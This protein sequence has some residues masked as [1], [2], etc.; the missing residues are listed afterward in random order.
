[1]LGSPQ[2][3]EVKPFRA[4][5]YDESTAGP[6]E[7]LVAPPYDVISP[8]QRD[9]YLARSPYNVVHLTLPDDEAQAGRD[10]TAWRE[11]GVLARETKP[12]YWLLAQDYVGPD[13]VSRTRSG[14]VASLRAEPY[15]SGT[16]L[17]HERTHRGPKEGRLRLLRATHTQLEPIFLL[18]EGEPLQPP[19]RTPDLESGG[20]KL[21]RADDA[22]SFESTELLIADGHHRYET[23]VAYA[24]EG[25][26]PYL[27]VVLVP[28]KQEGLTIFPTHRLA[29][30]VNGARGT[31]IDEPGDDLPGVVLYRNGRYELLSGEGLDV[32]I[33]EQIAPEGVTYTP[34][35]A[36]AVATVDRGDAEAAF[37]LRPT[38]IE[39]VWA[40]ARRGET[41]PQKSTYFYP[42]LT[43]GLLFHP[44]D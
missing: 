10:L 40:V 3:A 35:R 26:S 8:E 24:Q 34:Q 30:H 9:E 15:E 14:L 18:Y 1:M 33:V 11:Q 6:L 43:S 25:G 44:L 29:A 37:L 41:M 22:P 13:G 42:K 21:W 19:A 31:P 7:R 16:V 32:E 38:R 23:A 28:T 4:E 36:D 12:V 27:M 5:R 2:M 39:D 17:P 20:D